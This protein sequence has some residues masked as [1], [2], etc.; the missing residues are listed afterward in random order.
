MFPKSDP[1]IEPFRQT[2]E[3]LTSIPGILDTLEI[4]LHRADELPDIIARCG[5]RLKAEQL[6]EEQAVIGH[7][8]T[9]RVR[10]C[11]LESELRRGLLGI[12]DQLRAAIDAAKSHVTTAAGGAEAVQK[13][14]FACRHL[15]MLSRYRDPLTPTETIKLQLG[16]ISAARWIIDAAMGSLDEIRLDAQQ[17]RLITASRPPAP[18]LAAPRS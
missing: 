18:R 12:G 7:P 1:R 6:R 15:S 8:M 4:T 14:P 11:Q 5:C 9:L 13:F 2:V 10:Q 17:Q 16:L 3:R